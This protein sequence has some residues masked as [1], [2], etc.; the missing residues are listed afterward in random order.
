MAK[1]RATDI[2]GVLFDWDGTLLDSYRA[3]S[4]AYLAMFRQLGIAWGLNE[5]SQHYSPDWYRVYQ[6]AGLP[7]N[8]WDDADRAWR[9]EYAMHRPRLVTGARTVLQFLSR[10]YRVGLVTSGNRDRVIGQLRK[11]RLT[12]MFATCICSEDAE[13]RK[14]HPDPLVRALQNLKLKP[15]ACLYVGDAPEDL[16][17]AER[18][19]ARAVAIVGSFPTEKRL[20]AA[21]PKFLLESIQELPP[22]L[23]R[24]S[25]QE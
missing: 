9:K 15:A 2:Q 24:L 10:R 19:G 7:R 23:A 3:D 25:R 20:R 12:Q 13:R 14:P 6:A 5:L 11:L 18:A 16:E 4:A 1:L 21:R 8:R 22:L 17:M